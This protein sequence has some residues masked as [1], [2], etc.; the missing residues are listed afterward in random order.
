MGKTI[1]KKNWGKRKSKNNEKENKGREESRKAVREEGIR[2]VY[3]IIQ[4]QSKSKFKL[5]QLRVLMDS[6]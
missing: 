4:N 3:I 2:Y 6:M 1:I 5:F